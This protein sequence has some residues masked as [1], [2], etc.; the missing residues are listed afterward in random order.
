MKTDA[1]IAVSIGDIH[2]GAHDSTRL[3]E[4]MTGIFLKEV[5]DGADTID[6][7]AIDGDYWDKQLAASDSSFINGFRF[8]H[9]LHAVCKQNNIQLRMMR[10][11]VT[12]DYNQQEIFRS[13]ED[14]IFKLYTTVTVEEIAGKTCLFIPEEYP[15]NFEEHY[16][17]IINAPHKFHIAFMHGTVDFQ[18]WQCQVIESEKQYKSAPVWSSEMLSSVVS[19]PIMCGHIHTRCSFRDKIFYHS[20]FSRSHYGEE[21]EKG[22]NMVALFEDNGYEVAFVE[23]TLAPIKR[24]IKLKDI[25]DEFGTNASVEAVIAKINA[26]KELLTGKYDRLRVLIPNSFNDLAFIRMIVEYYA[27]AKTN[28]DVQVNTSERIRVDVN[29]DADIADAINE[30]HEEKPESEIDKFFQDG[31]EIGTIQKFLLL[32][33]EKDY[34]EDDIM[35]IIAKSKA[36]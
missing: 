11:T 12:H 22:F 2:W 32:K 9:R 4:E 3:Y 28:V 13:F 21:G 1:F 7:V 34:S 23:N 27:A 6:L 20:S 29:E 14:E 26:E 15:T 5:E 18:A 8:F 17:H 19:G 24:T 35:A 33:A 36:K 16:G 10:G 31:N 25:F 30:S